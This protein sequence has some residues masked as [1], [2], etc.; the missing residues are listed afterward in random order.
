M[1]FFLHSPSASLALVFD[2]DKGP[3]I[4][5]LCTSLTVKSKSGI[6]YPRHNYRHPLLGM[7]M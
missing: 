2:C 5:F 6:V 1:I 4:Y 3:A 7:M